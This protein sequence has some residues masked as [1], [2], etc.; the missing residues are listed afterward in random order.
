MTVAEAKG[1][2]EAGHFAKGSMEPKI[3]AAV[4]FIEHGGERAIITSL[5]RAVDALAGRAGTTITK[6]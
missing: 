5:N 3:R 2:S 4:R 1:Y 6:G